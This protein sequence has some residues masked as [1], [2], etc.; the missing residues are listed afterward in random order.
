M[1]H[2]P[3]RRYARRLSALERQALVIHEIYRYQVDAVLEGRGT[4]DPQALQAAV[5][6]A[7]EANPGIRVRLR[8]A[9]GFTRWVDSG[10][11]P[12]V[13]LLPA[14]DWDGSS[15]R[16]AEFLEERL[17]PLHGGAVADL[18]IVPGT[19]GLTRVVFR[20]VHAAVDGRGLMHWASEVLRA[21]RGEA[22]LG[23]QATLND[24][25]V[26]RQYRDRLPPPPPAPPPSI[27]IVAPSA[28]GRHPLRY[29]WR[30]VII[31]NDVSQ[32]LPKTAVFLAEWA[33][34]R[35]AGN[36]RFTIPVDYRGLRT[37]AMSI[38]NLL[39][40]LRLA[41]PEGATPRQLM[42]QLN[43][44]VRDCADCR[45]LP[46]ARLQLWIP[47]AS[48]LRKLRPAVDT[49]LYTATPGLPSGGIV[50]MG[51]IRPADV[52]F[53]G[54]EPLR[55]NGL[56][57][58]VGKLNIVCVTYPG[59]VSVTFAAPAAYNREGQLDALVQAYRQHFSK[60]A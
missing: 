13:R 24:L 51:A 7:A 56:P 30:R 25:D 35:E 3:R 58:A 18:L 22:L 43:Q 34:R 11:A 31:A 38:G 32:L 2:S 16:H 45:P 39:G 28:D 23:S 36:V 49:L 40:Y 10:I 57:G 5:D 4:V 8:G 54:F 12:R 21:M 50:S 27:P 60:P 29:V 42:Q 59:T 53:P 37:Q 52:A 20:S 47:I 17:D 6:R 26:Q 9:L 14:S 44:G 48:M 46:A 1:D 19:D 41:V 55:M 33:R 15:E